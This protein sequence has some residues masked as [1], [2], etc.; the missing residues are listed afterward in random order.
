MRT[1]QAEQTGPARFIPEEDEIFPEQPHRY[2]RPTLGQL[3]S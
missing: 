2:R 3:L 1:V